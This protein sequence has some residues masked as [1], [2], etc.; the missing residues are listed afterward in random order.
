MGEP[1]RLDAEHLMRVA[2]REAEKLGTEFSREGLQLLEQRI[3]RVVERVGVVSENQF[4]E[5]SDGTRLLVQL[6]AKGKLA[7]VQNGG[8]VIDS[9][10]FMSLKICPPWIWPFCSK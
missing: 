9:G 1:R 8:T 3:E 2:E 4:F 7:R 5:A 10:T 6:L